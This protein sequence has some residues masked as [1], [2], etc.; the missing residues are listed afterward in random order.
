MR[1]SALPHRS[2]VDPQPR[3][4]LGRDSCLSRT[5]R[6]QRLKIGA[7]RSWASS[8]WRIRPQPLTGTIENLRLPGDGLAAAESNTA[9]PSRPESA[10]NKVDGRGTERGNSG[11]GLT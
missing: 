10:G 2:A 9:N 7:V 6:H 4:G 1:P 3:Y 5:Q 11:R 8:V